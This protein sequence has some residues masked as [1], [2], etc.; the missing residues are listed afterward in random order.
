MYYLILESKLFYNFKFKFVYV[1]G[2]ISIFF[3]LWY[4]LIKFLFEIVDLIRFLLDFLILKFNV[5]D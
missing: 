4:I 1:I 2:V 5:L 3:V